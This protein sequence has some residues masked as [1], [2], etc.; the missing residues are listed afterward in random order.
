M[1]EMQAAVELPIIASGG[2]TTRDDVG[3]LAAV[4]M[5]GCII[6]RALYEGT[7]ALGD[8]LAAAEDCPGGHTD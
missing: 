7:L 4:P 5:A 6:G 3:R 1:A 8:A 2:I